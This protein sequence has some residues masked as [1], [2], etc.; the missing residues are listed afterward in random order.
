VSICIAAKSITR[1]IHVD[2]SIKARP[3]NL[4]FDLLTRQ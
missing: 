2:L 1:I 3:P 4:D